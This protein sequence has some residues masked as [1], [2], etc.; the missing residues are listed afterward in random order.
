MRYHPYFDN[1]WKALDGTNDY[2]ILFTSPA[3]GAGFTP[4]IAW[5]NPYFPGQQLPGDVNMG[6]LG[7]GTTAGVQGQI[8]TITAPFALDQNY[9][10]PF[11][12]STKIGF[13]IPNASE[14]TVIVYNA[15]GQHVATLLDS[16][17]SA[18]A[19]QVTF[20]G[21]RLSSGLYFYRLITGSKSLTG[22]MM[23]VK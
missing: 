15:L 4:P 10:N 2:R 16:Q 8:S 17:M 21:T 5:V 11:N 7:V 6:A 1:D 19:H 12:P 23:L 18:G 3:A 20:D 13:S 9:P 22:K 14:V